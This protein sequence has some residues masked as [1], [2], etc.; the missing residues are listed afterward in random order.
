MSPFDAVDRRI[1][2]EAERTAPPPEYPALP[3]IPGGRYNREDF[4]ALEQQRIWRNAWL[5]AGTVEGL[6]A[7]GEYR[8]FDKAGVPI[9]LVRGRDLQLRAFY[10]TC[11]HR[12]APVVREACGQAQLLRCQY[13]SWTYSLDGRLIGVPDERDFARLDKSRRGLAELRCE[14]W[15]GLIFV[16]GDANAEP[17]L[18]YLGPLVAELACVGTERLRVVEHRSYAINCNWKAAVDAFLEVY[19]LNTIHPTNAGIM[20]NSQAAA[21]GLMRRG[22]S[23]M[24]TRKNLNQGLNFVEFEDAPDIATMPDFFRRNNVAYTVFPNLVMPVEPTG[25]PLLLFWPR[26]L[27][28]TEMQAIYIAPDWGAGE[29]PA[30]WDRF[31]P[32]FDAVL[33]EDMMNLAPI[34]ASLDSGAFTGMSINYQ[35]RRI[36]WLHEE[37]DRRLGADAIP[38]GLAVAQVL[39]GFAE[40]AAGEAAT[41]AA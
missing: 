21:M 5:C 33:K 1:A 16:N 24:A 19:H 13:H 7:A 15:G 23:R 9:L 17:L 37:I 35:E 25:F 3:E 38:D 39:G 11:R 22:H 29:R 8:V 27:R 31:L 12:G 28:E 6:K 14:T 26:G 32:I 41:H 10:N 2:W 34:Q 40:D 30:F 20:L 4:Y 18:E 36:Y